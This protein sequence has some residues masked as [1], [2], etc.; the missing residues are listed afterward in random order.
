M[1]E[2]FQH[3]IQPQRN[4]EHF[5]HSTTPDQQYPTLP[6]VRRLFRRYMAIAVQS[7]LS[8]EIINSCLCCD[9]NLKREI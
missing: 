6:K 3:Q 4:K 5:C 8:A 7:I 2:V 9:Q 1:E